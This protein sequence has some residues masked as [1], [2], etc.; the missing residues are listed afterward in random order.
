MSVEES[1]TTK[2]DEAMR[3]T[4]RAGHLP[5][6]PQARAAVDRALAVVKATEVM[7]ARPGPEVRRTVVRTRR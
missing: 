5:P 1:P 3:M 2:V 4:P 7:I 6:D